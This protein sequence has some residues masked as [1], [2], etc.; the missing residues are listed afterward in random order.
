M[1]DPP[2]S[3]AVAELR[4]NWA[5]LNDLKRADAVFAVRQRGVS[6]RRLAGQLNCSEGL[7]RHLLR[8]REASAEDR[9]LARRGSIS[10]RELARRSRRGAVFPARSHEAAQFERA[11]AAREAGELIRAWLSR[12]QIRAEDKNQVIQNARELLNSAECNGTLPTFPP[13]IG[14]T[15]EDLITQCQPPPPKP[16]G[17]EAISWFGR[18][19]ELWLAYHI[20]DS[21]MRREALDLAEQETGAQ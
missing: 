8:A 1:S 3:I 17:S 18:W 16:N 21:Q 7:L 14:T 10:T 2:A 6:L 11:R 5:R 19:L 20:P 13:P 15:V 12:E 4:A 9:A